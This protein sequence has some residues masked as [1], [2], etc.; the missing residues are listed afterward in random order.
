MRI[1]DWSS[2]VCSSDLRKTVARIARD[3]GDGAVGQRHRA[4]TR[5]IE[6][7]RIAPRPRHL[8]QELRAG[9]D[10]P[11]MRLPQPRHR[12]RNVEIVGACLFDQPR[13]QR[14]VEPCPPCRQILLRT[15]IRSEEHTSE[16]KSLMRISYAVSSLKKKTTTP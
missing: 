15:G 7:P 13:Q 5:N 16:L 6:R 10:Q 9:L 14:I 8:R 1:S 12:L 4:G 3:R 11:F 2:D